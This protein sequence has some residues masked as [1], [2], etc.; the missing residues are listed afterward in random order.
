MKVLKI[1]LVLITL[2]SCSATTKKGDKQEYKDEYIGIDLHENWRFSEI[3]T[4]NKSIRI[5]RFERKPISESSSILN[6]IIAFNAD[7]KKF[8]QFQRKNTLDFFENAKLSEVSD[9]LYLNKQ[10]KMSTYSI[11]RNL[12]YVGANFSLDCKKFVLG[13]NYQF[14]EDE[15]E[16]SL[17]EVTETLNSIEI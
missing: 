16:K 8:H 11:N 6:L 9:I 7:Y 4:S 15:K 10:T 13:I 2:F 5:Y 3:D 17:K 1:V 14:S 12:N